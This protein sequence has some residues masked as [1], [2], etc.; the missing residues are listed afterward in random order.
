VVAAGKA[1]PASAR[2][3]QQLSKLSIDGYDIFAKIPGI[4]L[5]KIAMDP[6]Y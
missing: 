3:F 2:K 1:A 5:N 6:D 4:G